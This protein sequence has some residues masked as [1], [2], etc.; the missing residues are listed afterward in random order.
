MIKKLITLLLVLII[1]MTMVSVTSAQ[2]GIDPSLKPINSPEM[3]EVIPTTQEECDEKGGKWDDKTKFCTGTE[4]EPINAMLQI[5][6][7][8]ILMLSGGIAVIV[9]SVGGVMYITSRGNQQQL[10]FA[11]STLMYGFIGMIAIIFSYFII[12]W[13]LQIVIGL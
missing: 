1:T 12:R 6:A 9:M 2:R 13:V 8:A 5:L 4:D 10:E 11:K 7:G 3:P